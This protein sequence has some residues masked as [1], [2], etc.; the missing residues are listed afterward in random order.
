MT[1]AEQCEAIL[2]RIV[3]LVN[4]QPDRRVGFMPDWG[5]HS[6]TV[7]IDDAHSHVGDVQ[8]TWPE[9]VTG[10]YRLLCED[11]GLGFCAPGQQSSDQVSHVVAQPLSLG[12]YWRAVERSGRWY[13]WLVT[14]N[15]FF[16]RA[17][18]PAGRATLAEAEDDGAA[19]GLPR[20][21]EFNPDA[22]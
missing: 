13:L 20:W 19:T 7:C 15:G 6:L 2:R 16:L 3:E 10:L 8:A 11:T 17:P 12:A 1:T 4:G 9:L 18:V 21:P 14:A 5:G 22:P